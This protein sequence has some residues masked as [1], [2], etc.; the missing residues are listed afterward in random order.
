MRALFLC[1]ALC[2]LGG[3][4]SLIRQGA[5][6]FEQTGMEPERFSR[7][8]QACRNKADDYLAYDVR[9]QAL[10]TRYNQNRAFNDVYGRCMRSFGY[11]PRPYVKNLLPG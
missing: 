3:C 8:D 2:A 1:L 4:D 11:R 7:D 6:G 5:D 9:G 10:D